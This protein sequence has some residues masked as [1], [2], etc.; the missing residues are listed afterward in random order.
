M[1][2]INEHITKEPHLVAEGGR[3]K[4]RAPTLQFI[5]SEDEKHR[6]RF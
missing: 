2:V 4:N 5:L 3:P 1:P 6:Q